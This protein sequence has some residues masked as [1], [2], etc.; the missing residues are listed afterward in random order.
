MAA[1]QCGLRALG[2]VRESG[3]S[4]ARRI[5]ADT[6]KGTGSR[7][8]GPHNA[9]TPSNRS[10]CRH[11]YATQ[12][13]TTATDTWSDHDNAYIEQQTISS[14]SDTVCFRPTDEQFFHYLYLN[15]QLCFTSQSACVMG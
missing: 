11:P 8:I 10:N 4:A 5:P 2:P 15:S 7:S 6:R 14:V 13:N 1:E 12:Y 3:R 9:H